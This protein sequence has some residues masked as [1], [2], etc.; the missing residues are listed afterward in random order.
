MVPALQPSLLSLHILGNIA[1]RL[2]D[3]GGYHTI[4]RVLKDYYP[5]VDAAVFVINANDR[6]RFKESDVELA[7]LHLHVSV[8]V[9]ARPWKWCCWGPISHY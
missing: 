9:S 6:E 4:H 8:T 7:G 5:T 1:F 2:I 3:I